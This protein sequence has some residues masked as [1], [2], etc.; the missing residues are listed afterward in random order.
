VFLKPPTHPT[1]LY[2]QLLCGI[3]CYVVK[4]DPQR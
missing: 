2:G 4:I 3:D 1:H